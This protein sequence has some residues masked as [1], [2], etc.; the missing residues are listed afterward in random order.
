MNLSATMEKLSLQ[1][2][3]TP[4][5]EELLKGYEMHQ[6]RKQ[7]QCEYQKKY[8]EKKRTRVQE[9]EEDV[10]QLT[11]QN[12]KL[13]SY[14]SL[15]EMLRLQNP[16]LADQLVNQ[17]NQKT[18]MMPPATITSPVAYSSIFSPSWPHVSMQQ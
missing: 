15:F 16:Q 9:L 12:H 8:M 2:S 7:K 11:D 10:R 3:N 18:V 13:M 17:L 1:E 6:K 14:Y 4:P 5:L